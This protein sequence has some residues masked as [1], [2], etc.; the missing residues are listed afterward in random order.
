M[1]IQRIIFTTAVFTKQIFIASALLCVTSF[2]VAQDAKIIRFSADQQGDAVLLKWTV[3]TGQTC[4]TVSV[5]RTLDTTSAFE[6]LYLYP[7]VCGNSQFEETYTY[8]DNSPIKHATN[9]YRL[10]YGSGLTSIASVLFTDYGNTGFVVFQN[11]NQITLRYNNPQNKRFDLSLF[12]SAGREVLQRNGIAEQEIQFDASLFSIGL[13]F[14]RLIGSD[15]TAYHGK[16]I[17]R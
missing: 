10:D 8:T 9:Y 2:A 7:G 15:G 13:Y 3:G 1:I 16:F 17:L 14:V 4:Y 11:A 5:Q 12:D 6:S